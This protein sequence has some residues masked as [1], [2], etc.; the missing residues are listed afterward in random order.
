MKKITLVL[1][2]AIFTG[3]IFAQESRFSIDVGA[4][5]T[6]ETGDNVSSTDGESLDM[7]AGMFNI[8]KAGAFIDGLYKINDFVAVGGELGFYTMPSEDGEATALFDIP[9]LAI[10]QGNLFDIIKVKGHF[11][12]TLSNH[13]VLDSADGLEYVNK[14]DLGARFFL[15][16]LYLDYSV[17]M[18]GD[19]KS[20]VKWGL[21]YTLLMI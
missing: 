14:F 9:L 10:L 6:V 12:Y 18:W 17:L 15:G 2:V 8:F 5:L 20:S 1:L 4:A 7:L 11:G 19:S 13:L 16:G 3:T 21:G